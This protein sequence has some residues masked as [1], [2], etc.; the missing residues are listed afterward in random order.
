MTLIRYGG[1]DRNLDEAVSYWKS[2]LLLLGEASPGDSPETVLARADV[3]VSMAAAVQKQRDFAQANEYYQEAQDGMETAL[4]VSTAR[5]HPTYARAVSDQAASIYMGK[6]AEEA[7][8]GFE[9]A[10][11]CYGEALAASG[12]QSV[13]DE[14]GRWPRTEVEAANTQLNLGTALLDAADAA[15]DAPDSERR[16]RAENLLTELTQ[17]YSSVT[18]DARLKAITEA[19]VRLLAPEPPAAT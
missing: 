12:D 16:T 4:G 18:S 3:L 11:A 6:S 7:V 2:S 19:A 10:L 9:R 15:Q 1:Q 5:A 17:K 14:N 13:G 8:T